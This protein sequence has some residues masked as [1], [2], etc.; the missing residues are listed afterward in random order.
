VIKL[1][2]KQDHVEVDSSCV[3][4][5]FAEIDFDDLDFE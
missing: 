1:E 5:E 3:A 2:S 4:G